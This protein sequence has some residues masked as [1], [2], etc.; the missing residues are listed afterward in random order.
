MGQF[1]K[2]VE[3]WIPSV[4]G[5]TLELG[6]SHYGELEGFREA[7]IDLTFAPGEGLP[8]RTWAQARPII[9][10][11]LQDP[12][13]V[14]SESAIAAKLACAVSLPVFCGEFLQAVV[15]L[16]CGD[17]KS[18]GAL[19]VWQNPEES[20][21]ELRLEDGYFGDLDR[22]EWIT[23]NLTIMRGR[24]LPGQAWSEAGPVIIDNLGESSTFLRASKAAEVGMTTGLAIPL[25]L[26][27]NDVQILTLLSTRGTPIASTF[28]IWK[29]DPSHE[30]LVYAS[31][32][33]L[34]DDSPAIAYQG[35]I[36]SRGE[37]I[38]GQVWMTGRPAIHENHEEKGAAVFAMPVINR[39]ELTGVVVMAL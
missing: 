7:S 14:R 32:V 10:K 29:P 21:C 17:E 34:N 2:A 38:V 23:R 19:E 11:D 20:D 9:L 30:G 27:E 25:N 4:S 12:L 6:S 28:E 35:K 33:S 22:F 31:G 26:Q 15:I 13:F 24:G 36:V 39:G 5:L 1:V 37:G 18:T 3:V 8:G 16:F